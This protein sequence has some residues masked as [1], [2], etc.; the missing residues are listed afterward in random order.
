[1]V[2]ETLFAVPAEL[3]ARY[4]AG[5]LERVG[6]LLVDPASRQIVAHMQETAG[7]TRAVGE[8]LRAV[9][10]DPLSPIFDGVTVWQNEQIKAL[11]GVQQT[12]AIANLAAT[13]IGIGVSVAG[14]ALIERRIAGLRQDV[15][16]LAERIERLAADLDDLKAEAVEADLDALRTACQQVDEAWHLADPEAQWR[17]CAR[18]LHELQTRFATRAGKLIERWTSRE[19]LAGIDRMLSALLL[20][21]A[22]RIEARMACGDMEVAERAAEQFA[23]DIRRATGQ[24][25]LAALL[26]PERR[27]LAEGAEIAA[28]IQEIETALPELRRRAAV[29]RE[30]EQAAATRPVVLGRLIEAGVSGRAY[31]EEARSDTDT[32]LRLWTPPSRA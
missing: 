20:A 9:P 29:Y 1:M 4:A 22:A 14:F 24:L 21:A 10:F 5:G 30:W 2:G 23:A 32:A 16:G 31:L 15:A 26:A 12:L 19:D 8:A 17:D 3:T 18:K 6:A 13:G 11:L 27:R 25:G 28:L 7:T